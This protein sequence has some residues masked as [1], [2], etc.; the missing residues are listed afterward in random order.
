MAITAQSTT[1]MESELPKGPL[2]QK[3]GSAEDSVNQWGTGNSHHVISPLPSCSKPFELAGRPAGAYVYTYVILS[4]MLS[5]VSFLYV[6]GIAQSLGSKK[7]V[8]GMLLHVE[9]Y[10]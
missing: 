10:L 2:A 3:M 7:Y 1:F 6:C 4:V 8:C 5:M 9:T